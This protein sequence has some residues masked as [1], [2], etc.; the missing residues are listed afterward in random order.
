MTTNVPKGPL[1]PSMEEFVAYLQLRNR[2]QTARGVA[3]VLRFFSGWLARERLDPLT[4]TTAQLR[5]YQAY[6]A[7]VQRTEQGELLSPGTQGLRLRT[8]KSYFRWLEIRGHLVADPARRLSQREVRSRVVVREY[9][10]LQ[11]ATALLQTQAAHAASQPAESHRWAVEVRNL[12]MITIGIATGRRISG[13]IGLRIADID[14]DRR[15]TRV[16]HEKGYAGRVVPIAGWAIEV[17]DRYLRQARPILC[18]DPDNPWLFVGR[19]GRGSSNR[20]TMW[21]ALELMVGRTVA[22]NPDLEELARKRITWHSLRVSFATLLFSGGADIR[23][24]NEL[25]LHRTL[26]ATAK[27]TPVPVEDLRQVC[28]AA[29][30]RA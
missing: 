6:V 4:V 8:L 27:Y 26:T 17:L 9:L 28:L 23:S 20:D 24:V 30:P 21:S 10:S 7:T 18:Q 14:V 29:H 1:H 11:E 3:M 19:G 16:E 2:H 25:M 12:A 15:E 5:E 13:I 22:Q